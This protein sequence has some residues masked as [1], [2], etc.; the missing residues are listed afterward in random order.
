ME[1]ENELYEKMKALYEGIKEEN[2]QLK[3]KMEHDRKVF[4]WG[5]WI[6]LSLFVIS[7]IWQRPVRDYFDFKM[8]NE[9]EE[10][11]RKGMLPKLHYFSVECLECDKAMKE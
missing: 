4:Q 2:E 10:C 8:E 9:K 5:F 1:Q 6:V 3:R 7:W 11:L